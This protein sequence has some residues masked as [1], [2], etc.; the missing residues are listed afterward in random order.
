MRDGGMV[1]VRELEDEFFNI[2]TIYDDVPVADIL[3]ALHQAGWQEAWPAA[4]PYLA[5]P[6][7]DPEAAERCFFV[8]EA[9]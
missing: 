7:S 1:I 2:R 5:E 4:L 3:S 9:R 6:L 8:A